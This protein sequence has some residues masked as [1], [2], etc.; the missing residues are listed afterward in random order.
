MDDGPLV[1]LCSIK[2]RER[3]IKKWV[4]NRIRCQ[5]RPNVSIHLDIVW[6]VN[7]D[8]PLCQVKICQVTTM[9][10]D[11]HHLQDSEIP[12]LHGKVVSS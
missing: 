2:F 11:V 3:L 1:V 4:W 8:L 6:T 7:P 10:N 12:K 9:C 5:L